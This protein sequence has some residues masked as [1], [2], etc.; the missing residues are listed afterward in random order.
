MLMFVLSTKEEKNLEGIVAAVREL[1]LQGV[2]QSA[3]HI[4]N[5]ARAVGEK[6]NKLA[7]VWNLSG[8]IS[9]ES[10]VI[11]AK[12]SVIRNI[13][14]KHLKNYRLMFIGKGLLKSLKWIHESIRPLEV[15]PAL[16]DIYELQD[17]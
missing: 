14:K 5:K 11:S 7:G 12:K 9:G 16:R 8:N 17:G 10:N 3:V 2:V 15:Y 4:A 6:E 13:F 1:K